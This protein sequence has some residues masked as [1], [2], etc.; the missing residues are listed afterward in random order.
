M[1]SPENEI[2]L[3]YGLIIPIKI[4][5]VFLVYKIQKQ[6]KNFREGDQRK[7]NK[8]KILKSEGK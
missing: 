8:S 5:N 6:G 3:F 7:K 2:N 1:K 4:I